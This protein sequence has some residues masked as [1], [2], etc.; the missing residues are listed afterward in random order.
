[1]VQ[2]LTSMDEVLS[3][4]PRTGKNP[5]N[6]NQNCLNLWAGEVSHNGVIASCTDD[7]LI[8]VTKCQRKGNLREKRFVWGSQLEGDG[9]SWWGRYGRRT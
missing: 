6:I 4:V 3:S 7:I 2:Y 5:H 8:A 1:M 9:P